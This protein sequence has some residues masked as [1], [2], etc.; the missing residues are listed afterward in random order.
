MRDRFT[1]ILENP[2][3]IYGIYNSPRLHLLRKTVAAKTGLCY[4][5]DI[6]E[7]IARSRLLRALLGRMC[8]CT[9]P[10]E[11]KRR[12]ILFIHIPRCGGISVSNALYGNIRDHQTASYFRNV[13]TEFF[14][15]AF[16]FALVRHPVA[17]ALSAFKYLL[18]NGARDM[19]FDPG[20]QLKTKH[21]STLDQYLSFLE[22]NFSRLDQLDY[23]MRPQ[24]QFVLDGDGIL[25]VDKLFRLERDMEA[26]NDLFRSW[27]LPRVPHM[28][29]TPP[30]QLRPD[31][32]QTDR[33]LAL[34]A[35]D[36]RMYEALEQS[37]PL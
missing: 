25:L 28:N 15:L 36:L 37:K 34:Y 16:K 1:R 14:S 17:R 30:I 27:G 26:L 10:A 33:I 12:N 11:C 29:A 20:W 4:W 23:V 13:D 9:I 5:G 6:Q 35:A 7:A 3:L 21:I 32:R 18:N 22:E 31:Q 8:G 2:R 24:A 19:A